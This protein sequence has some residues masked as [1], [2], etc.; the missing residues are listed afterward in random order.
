MEILNPE[1]QEHIS[2]YDASIKE[3]KEAHP[4]LTDEKLKNILHDINFLDTKDIA[5]RG[6]FWPFGIVGRDKF[7]YPIVVSC[8][9]VSKVG[10]RTIDVI[11]SI[12]SYMTDFFYCIGMFYFI[13]SWFSPGHVRWFELIFPLA[14]S[15]IYYITSRFFNCSHLITEVEWYYLEQKKKENI[16]PSNKSQSGATS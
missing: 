14:C 13:L 4:D 10:K 5:I 6:F 8:V 16:E 3:L 12:I 2:F 15:F 7:F 9:S 1:V 11:C